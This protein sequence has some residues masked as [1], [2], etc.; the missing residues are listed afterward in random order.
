MHKHQNTDTLNSNL[1]E[2]EEKYKSLSLLIKLA[3]N[4][5]LSAFYYGYCLT[6][7]NSINYQHIVSIFNLE[8]YPRAL[9]QGCLTGSTFFTGA[10]GTI[11]STQLI[12][13]FSRR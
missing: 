9:T 12:N 10:I 4:C 6:Y 2:S 3:L 8:D 5:G 11:L 7:F 1:L 13:R